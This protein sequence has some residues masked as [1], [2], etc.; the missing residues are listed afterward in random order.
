MSFELKLAWRYFRSSRK[1]LVRFTSVVALIGIAAGVASLII[2]QAIAQGFRDEI[3]D[4]ILSNS[5]HIV[6]SETNDSRIS[7]WEIVAKKIKSINGVEK[8]EP[9][10]FESAVFSSETK[11]S[12]AIIRVKNWKGG[13]VSKDGL[14]KTGIEIAVGKELAS[15]L[16]LSVGDN[17]DLLTF[18]GEET[19]RRVN[20]SIGEIFET[21]L[22]EYDSAWIYVAQEDYLKLKNI[23]RFS[24]T[25]YSVFVKDI[26]A[27]E[28]ISGEIESALGANFKVLDWREANKPLFS[29]LSLERKVS[30]AIISLI[31]F[32]AALNITTTLALLVN[33][34]RYDIGV[35]K[36]FGASKK[37][38]AA[39][40]FF[41]G[42]ILSVVGIISGVAIGL[43]ACF[44]GNYF[45]VISLSKE[46]YSLNY[47]PFNVNPGG[48]FQIAAIAFLLCLLAI[49]YPAI[50]AGKVKPVEN[51]KTL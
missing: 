49:I 48:V 26:Y 11:S 27:T 28:K 43:A 39:M 12:H 25:V 34:R 21:G 7:N 30:L 18:E 40:F 2:A 14:N 37:N 1:N 9:T 29:A 22:Y 15:G 42:I 31:I 36:T 51:L 47:V 19:P 50:R 46:V 10:S 20:V 6:V 33:E 3:Q 41:E 13:G 45:R 16:E 32:I 4:K 17:S 44:A 24:P 38:I 23:E 35:L 8:V 5:A